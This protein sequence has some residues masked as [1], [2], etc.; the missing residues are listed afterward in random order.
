M[1]LKSRP[2]SGESID[3][4]S[5]AKGLYY[6]FFFMLPWCLK[7]DI[8]LVAG[9]NWRKACSQRKKGVNA[10]DNMIKQG[11]GRMN[12]PPAPVMVRVGLVQ[13]FH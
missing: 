4:R 2:A 8:R 9:G 6:A 13:N 12:Y 3:L 1:K 11:A 5:S 7:N 10:S